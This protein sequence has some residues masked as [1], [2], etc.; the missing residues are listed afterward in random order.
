MVFGGVIARVLL[1]TLFISFLQVESWRLA[2]G[3]FVDARFRSSAKHFPGIVVNAWPD[4]QHYM[5]EF[6]DGDRASKV[7]RAHV[8][9]ECAFPLPRHAR[10][11]TTIQVSL[12]V[13]VSTLFNYK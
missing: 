9:V 8:I 2:P 10:A 7:P 11:A 13:W 12:R 3:F 5:V 1:A 4:G 6:D